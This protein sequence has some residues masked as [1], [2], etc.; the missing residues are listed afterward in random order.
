MRSVVITS[1]LKSRSTP[2]WN[3]GSFVWTMLSVNSSPI[4]MLM[5]L[6]FLTSASSL[7]PARAWPRAACQESCS[8]NSECHFYTYFT[9]EDADHPKF[10]FLLAKLSNPITTCASCSTGPKQCSNECSLDN[11]ETSTSVMLT[12]TSETSVIMVNGLKCTLTFL[13]TGEVCV[14]IWVLDCSASVPLHEINFQYLLFLPLH[15]VQVPEYICS[16]CFQVRDCPDYVT[17]SRSGLMS[18]KIPDKGPIC[19]SS[20]DVY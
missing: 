8:Q 7:T 1:L 3:A 14:R 6:L 4:S 10:C 15:F 12:N 16:G 2:S 11:G 20:P 17:L 5:L 13:L 18:K 19:L 9:Q